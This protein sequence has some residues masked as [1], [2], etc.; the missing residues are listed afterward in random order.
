MLA[1]LAVLA[2]IETAAPPVVELTLSGSSGT[3]VSAAPR[4]LSDFARER[5][6]GARAVGGFSA[7]E[8]TVT[9]G[10]VFLPALEQDEEETRPEPEVVPEPQPPGWVAPY[11]WTGGWFGGNPGRR[12]PH[13]RL[14]LRSPVPP[15]RR[16]VAAPSARPGVPQIPWSAAWLHSARVRP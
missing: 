2:A 13:V 9:R 7:V 16:P 15:A 3:P 6:L 8:T 12:P 5:R 14:F 11:D 4:S 1:V 10:P